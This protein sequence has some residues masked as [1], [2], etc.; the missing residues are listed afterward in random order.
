LLRYRSHGDQRLFSYGFGTTAK[1]MAGVATA[2]PQDTLVA[3]T[4][5]AGMVFR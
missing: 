4:N 1:G 5:P 2:L 3:A